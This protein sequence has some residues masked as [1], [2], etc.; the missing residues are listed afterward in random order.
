MGSPASVTTATVEDEEGETQ[1]ASGSSVSSH[2]TTEVIPDRQQ[3]GHPRPIDGDVFYLHI[4]V[5]SAQRAKVLS[6]CHH[7]DVE[8]TVRYSGE[9]GWLAAPGSDGC[10]TQQKLAHARWDRS[11]GILEHDDFRL[12]HILRWRGSWR[13]LAWRID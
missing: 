3:H 13:I 10:K 6:W 7:N 9:S 11:L 2:E 8:L 5:S 4:E 12:T 1:G